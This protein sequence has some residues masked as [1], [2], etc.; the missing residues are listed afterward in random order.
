MLRRDGQDYSTRGQSVLRRTYGYDVF[1]RDGDEIQIF[2]R[3][4]DDY[5]TASVSSDVLALRRAEF[6]QREAERAEERFRFQQEQFTAAE[7]RADLQDKRA[8]EAAII[9]RENARIARQ[10]AAIAQEQLDLA[11]QN[12]QRLQSAESRAETAEARAVRDEARRDSAEARALDAE[13]RARA[14]EA[15]LDAR[16]AR[17]IAAEA[18]A[19]AADARAAAAEAR[20]NRQLA[21]EE[22]RD[23][24]ADRQ[25]AL[26]E[27]SALIGGRNA[28]LAEQSAARDLARSRLSLGLEDKDIVYIGGEVGQQQAMPMPYNRQLNLAETIYGSRGIEPITGDP[29]RIYVV[30]VKSSV[31][32]SVESYIFHFDGGNLANTAAMT[33]FEMRPQD[34]VLVM[35]R[36]ITNWSRFIT[37]LVPTLNT[38]LSAART[39]T[40]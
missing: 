39:A 28:A 26:A 9:A 7:Q 24:R 10:N 36:R 5:D 33:M 20:S 23:A 11:R 18:R 21:L 2:D 22:L 30:R 27:E 3:L 8:E 37:Q 31:A 17:D 40:I 25:L 19:E 35:P 1:L 34:L 4:L 32:G 12:S 13:A 15:R 16:E 38:V 14:A 6:E 29:S